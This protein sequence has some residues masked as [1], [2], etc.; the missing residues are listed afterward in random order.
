MALIPSVNHR[1]TGTDAKAVLGVIGDPD[2]VGRVL[3]VLRAT[4][5]AGD[6]GDGAGGH[7]C[8]RRCCPPDLPSMP[9]WTR[10]RIEQALKDG[11]VNG[12]AS[13]NAL[14]LGIDIGGLD[15][16]ILA[17]Y[18]GTMMSTW[19]QAGRAGR[20]SATALVTLVAFEG[21]LDQYLARHPKE[22]LTKPHEHAV[23]DLDNPYILNGHVLCAAAELPIS[24][25]DEACFGPKL[26][27]ALAHWERKG[28]LAKTSA[29]WVY[30][31]RGRP[32]AEVSLDAIDAGRVEVR[33]NDA[34]GDPSQSSR[35][36]LLEVLSE[37]RA[38]ASAHPG[39]ILYHQGDSYRILRLDL[40]SGV[41]TAQRVKTMEYTEP[42]NQPSIAVAAEGR[43]RPLNGG[44][45]G[46]VGS[47][48]F[49]GRVE[50]T[51]E[52]VGYRR[53]RYDRVVQTCGLE[54]PPV[55]FATVG[56]WCVI[57]RR[58]R[59]A[60]RAAGWDWLGGLHA[61][62]HAMIHLLP[63]FAMC[64][65]R[66]LGGMSTAAHP[67]VGGGAVIFIYDGYQAGSAS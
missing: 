65:K 30:H 28:R 43:R 50:V 25:R 22:L 27:D 18:P 60:V 54:L 47:T 12:V 19:Q 11:T 58:I 5:A 2:G 53:K 20:G 51:D 42:I 9:R 29:G 3:E 38:Y 44:I 17:S 33:C 67:D 55:Q 59:D 57:S 61:A 8:S 56:V 35:G 15:A 26:P 37:R 46:G 52:F 21:P 7:W 48:L 39:A 10:R 1:G 36:R 41:A 16:A 4:G 49:V 13:T 6:A 32:V 64:D 63:L 40:A 23:V 66:D 14:E 24:D 62:E 45:G 31:G 34:N